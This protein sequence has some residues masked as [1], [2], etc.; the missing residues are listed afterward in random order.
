MRAGGT[1]FFLLSAACAPADAECRGASW[2]PG[3]AAGCGAAATVAR[4]AVR[5]APV[6]AGLDCVLREGRGPRGRVSQGAAAST[7]IPARQTLQV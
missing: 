6:K 2:S 5:G 1:T 4:G 7:R 3:A